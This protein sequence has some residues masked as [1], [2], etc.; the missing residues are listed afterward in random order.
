MTTAVSP[1]GFSGG[2]S[3]K[4]TLNLQILGSVEIRPIHINTFHFRQIYGE[5]IPCTRLE[6]VLYCPYFHVVRT[7]FPTREEAEGS[8]HRRA[9]VGIRSLTSRPR[10]LPL[11]LLRRERAAPLL[12]ILKAARLPMDG[13]PT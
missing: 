5:A 8:N 13:K 7:Y 3:P 11:R 1:A 6:T 12:S 2:W 4:R 9:V 10:D